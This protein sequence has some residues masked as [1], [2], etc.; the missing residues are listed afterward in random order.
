MAVLG[1]AGWDVAAGTKSG[2][3]GGGGRR[4]VQANGDLGQMTGTVGSIDRA[5]GNGMGMAVAEAVAGGDRPTDNGGRCSA[6]DFSRTR[7][8]SGLARGRGSGGTGGIGRCGARAGN[9]SDGS[10]DGA[11]T[12]SSKGQI[13]GAAGG[14]E[15]QIGG[16]RGQMTGAIGGI[17]KA[18][19]SWGMAAATRNGGNGVGRTCAVTGGSGARGRGG[20]TDFSR[21]AG[22]GSRQSAQA[23]NSGWAAG[24]AGTNSRDGSRAVHMGSGGSN[25]APTE[26]A[27][28]TSGA[29]GNSGTERA[30]GGGMG[31]DG[32]RAAD[33]EH[34]GNK[35][36]RGIGAW[37]MSHIGYISRIAVLKSCQLA[38]SAR[39]SQ[40][41]V[42]VS[43]DASSV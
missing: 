38:G 4:G 22:T 20:I 8:S 2:G 9:G 7:G 6:E 1:A 27:G 31:K 28:G 37:A 13:T 24:G 14:M 12:G 10:V 16:V 40:T 42:H 19:I 23:G 41:A 43:Q 18:G 11:P 29:G 5:K 32:S 21:A 33:T 34:S 35:G 25:R 36:S 39:V 26:V 17:D 15:A 30:A 3:I